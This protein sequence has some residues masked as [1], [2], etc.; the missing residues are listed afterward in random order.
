MRDTLLYLSDMLQSAERILLYANGLTQD[1]FAHDM[2]TL[3]A[4]I[5]NLQ[6]IGEAANR[7]PKE[8]QQKYPIIAWREIIGFRNVIVHSY[9][10][11][12]TD[13]VWEIV[14]RDVPQLIQQLKRVIKSEKKK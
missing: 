13:L 8:V 3:D 14:K 4:I 11:I 10:G 2:K 12:D 5:R 1:Q 7:V 9:F 6:I